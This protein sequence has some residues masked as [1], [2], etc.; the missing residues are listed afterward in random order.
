MITHSP[1]RGY[2][3][4]LLFH[5]GVRHQF[6]FDHRTAEEFVRFVKE[7]L[8]PVEYEFTPVSWLVFSLIV[9]PVFSPFP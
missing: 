3:T 5:E 8:E 1:C 2:P 7:T 9:L 4:F 6:D